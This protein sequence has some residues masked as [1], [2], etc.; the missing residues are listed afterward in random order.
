M[1][2]EDVAWFAGL[3]EGEGSLCRSTGRNCWRM[4]LRMTDEDVVRRIHSLFGGAVY[5]DRRDV[6]TNG[7][8]KRAWQWQV[9]K[10]EEINKIVLSIRPHMGQRRG[11]KMDEFLKYF[12]EPVLSHSDRLKK[13]WA[14]SDFRAR[15]SRERK[16]RWNDPEWR[17]RQLIA[18]KASG[19]GVNTRF[20]PGVVS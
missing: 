14:D 17:A 6:I 7:K 4:S 11:A 10:Q 1:K 8:H 18:M 20:K 12:A 16:D 5:D 9:C 13:V 3:F 19:L 15:M 2:A